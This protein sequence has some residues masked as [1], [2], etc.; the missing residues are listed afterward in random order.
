MIKGFFNRIE[1]IENKQHEIPKEQEQRDPPIPIPSAKAKCTFSIP[2]PPL[3]P[4]GGVSSRFGRL[5]INLQG[6]SKPACLK[7]QSYTCNTYLRVNPIQFNGAGFWIDMYRFVPQIDG[8]GESTIIIDEHFEYVQSILEKWK[9]NH[10]Q[11][12]QKQKDSTED[13]C[14]KRFWNIIRRWSLENEYCT[15]GAIRRH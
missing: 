6:T 13:L 14:L 11:V 9:K 2:L 7:L 1:R 12:L 3:W 15:S 8:C 10:L 5:E 4:I